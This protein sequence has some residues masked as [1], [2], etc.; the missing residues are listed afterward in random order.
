MHGCACCPLQSEAHFE[1][2]DQ[3][4]SL[5]LVLRLIC[6]WPVCLSPHVCLPCAPCGQVPPRQLRA[7]PRQAPAIRVRPKGTEHG[8][9]TGF[10]LFRIPMCSTHVQ[11][12]GLSEF[13]EGCSKHPTT[14]P[15]THAHTKI[16][17]T[18]RCP[19]SCG[20]P[21]SRRRRLS[22]ATPSCPSTWRLP[23]SSSQGSRSSASSA[24][25]QLRSTSKCF[26]RACAT[27]RRPTAHLHARAPST[28]AVVHISPAASARH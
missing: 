22:T 8:L 12:R 28:P 20:A 10:L 1:V 4:S 2:N 21:G 16:K 19:F 17:I 14:P 3:S 23:S 11:A 15:H 9:S 18:H 7:R 25:R 26:R 13:G 27:C 5:S 6:V 24:C